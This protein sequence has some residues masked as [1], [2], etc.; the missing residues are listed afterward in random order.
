[1]IVALFNIMG[2]LPMV[3]ACLM[4]SDG[5]T[6]KIKAGLF[7]AAA[8][9]VGAFAILP[10]LAIR[11]PNQAPVVSD[12]KLIRLV[13]SRWLAIALSVGIIVLLSYGISQGNWSDFVQQWLNSRFIHVMSL[14]FVMLSLLL[15]VLIGDDISRRPVSNPQLLRGISLVPLFGGLLYL[16][17]RPPL[18][19]LIIDN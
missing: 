15:P 13:D 6:Q 5:C 8:F 14:D 4:L 9:A 3:Y 19:T 16:C 18:P 2:I 12:S 17:L 11:Q 7:S 1:M 10:Y